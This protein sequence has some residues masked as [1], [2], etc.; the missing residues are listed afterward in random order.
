[1]ALLLAWGP[2]AAGP[3]SGRIRQVAARQKLPAVRLRGPVP[4][5]GLCMV[6]HHWVDILLQECCKRMLACLRHLPALLGVPPCKA[7]VA[8]SNMGPPGW[9][10]G[11]SD[12][13]A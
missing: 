5:Y 12:V 1:M 11:D 9:E 4:V 7:T 8:E 10:S 6:A 2:A 13:L 3:L